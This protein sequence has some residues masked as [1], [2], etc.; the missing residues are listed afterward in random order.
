[1]AIPGVYNPRLQKGVPHARPVND[2]NEQGFLKRR[3]LG[4]AQFFPRCYDLTDNSELEDFKLDHRVTKSESMLKKCFKLLA[5]P[6]F[7]YMLHNTMDPKS[8]SLIG[9]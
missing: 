7:E 8:F 6:K 2:E 1:M 3:R 9:S 5:S 4:V